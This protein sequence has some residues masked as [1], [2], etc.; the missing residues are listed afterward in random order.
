MARPERVEPVSDE[1]L[2]DLC[3]IHEQNSE[4]HETM[5]AFYKGDGESEMAAAME[6]DALQKMFDASA[7]AATM[8][9][10]EKKHAQ[11]FDSREM[12]GV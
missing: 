5:A 7:P 4:A 12:F 10:P 2:N 1:E 8:Y 11:T 3:S 6:T 9:A